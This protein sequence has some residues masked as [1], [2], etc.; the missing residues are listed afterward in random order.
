MKS[1]KVRVFSPLLAVF[2]FVLTHN[3][4]AVTMSVPAEQQFFPSYSPIASPVISADPSQAMPIGVGPIATGGD[5]LNIQ[6]G[7]GQF[8]GLVDIYFGIYS[9]LID[10]DNVYILTSGNTFQPFYAGFTPWMADTY[11]DINE[12]LF[13]DISASAILPGTYDLYLAVTPSGSLDAYYLWSTKFTV[14]PP[15]QTNNVLPITVNGS[16]CSANSYPNKPCVSVTVCTPGT[17]TCQ[18]IYDI[19]LDTGS[20]G[21]RIFKQ[22]LNVS[23]AQEVTA[24]GSLAE[25]V[26]FGDGSSDWG[27]VQTASII[28]GNEP[29]VEVPIQVIDS[30]FGIA[31]RTCQNAEQG[32]AEAGFNGILGVGFFAED[33]GSWCASHAGNG[34]YYSCSGTNCTGTTAALS[35]QVKNPVAY[36]PDDNNG[37]IV[38]LPG[39]TPEG[40][41]SVNGNLILGIGTQSNNMPSGVLT[42]AADQSG[43]FI[44]FFNGIFYNS[45]IDS[46][47]N[48]LFFPSPSAVLLPNCAF[49][50]TAW[51]CPSSITD[52]SA[53]TKGV[54]GSA[55]SVVE[56]Q[57][58]NL[59]SLSSSSNNVFDNIGGEL[60]GAFD[61]GL[62]FFLGRTVF[63]GFDGSQSGL[64]KGPYWAY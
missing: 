54:F 15:L 26:Q 41:P 50:N 35:S 46:G 49:P 31:P 57:I 60:T 38:Q 63:L 62:P 2:V 30:T 10:P 9:S 17:S 53:T 25:C 3:A 16:L 56:F 40:A 34:M 51:F 39:V 33:C 36:L 55:S 11:G 48:G 4:F 12:S 18:I 27:P 6:V 23:L 52:L 61:W 21:L 29:A 28:L 14:S 45:F 64:G 43:E 7:L 19:L 24:A 32:P 5:T 8:S 37:V 1:N 44:T 13:G 58:G 59:I 22:A 42:Y 20:F 47:S